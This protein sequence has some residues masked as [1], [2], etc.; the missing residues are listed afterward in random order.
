M[1][2]IDEF[3]KKTISRYCRMSDEHKQYRQSFHYIKYRIPHSSRFAIHPLAVIGPRKIHGTMLR[4]VIRPTKIF[5][6]YSER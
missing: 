5:T 2:G 6:N 3:V 1:E 4:L